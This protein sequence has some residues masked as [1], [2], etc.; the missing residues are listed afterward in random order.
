MLLNGERGGNFVCVRVC[1]LAHK[2]TTDGV[3]YSMCNKENDKVCVSVTLCLFSK[4]F[5]PSC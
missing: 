3:N 2:C 5:E 4:L 1:V